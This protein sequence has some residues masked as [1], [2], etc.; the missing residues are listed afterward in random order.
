MSKTVSTRPLN[1]DDLSS[2]VDIDEKTSGTRKDAFWEGKIQIQESSR[3]PWASL[4]A[5]V[6]NEVVGFL[7]SHYE[8]LEFG[9]PGSIAWIDIIGVDPGY[10][11]LGVAS[12]LMGHLTDAAEDVGI[13]R[14]FT[15]V[16]DADPHMAEFFSAQG[17]SHGAMKHFRKDLSGKGGS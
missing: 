13:D 2:I 9:L 8:E 15:L 4:V 11:R 17:F 12:K 3:P 7:F 16:A 5:V 10:R 14:I 6:D 1:K